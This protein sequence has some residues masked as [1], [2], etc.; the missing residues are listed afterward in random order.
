M[1]VCGEEPLISDPLWKDAQ[2]AEVCAK[3][4]P[5]QEFHASLLGGTPTFRHRMGD[6]Q[7]A[8]VCAAQL[9]QQE[10]HASLWTRTPTSRPPKGDAQRAE[11]ASG[12]TKKKIITLPENPTS[13]FISFM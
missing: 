12:S 6:A 13:A 7:K 5:E 2:N 9:P 11:I 4:R 8:E 10:F 1:R 3:K